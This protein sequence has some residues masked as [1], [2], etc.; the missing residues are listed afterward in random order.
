MAIKSDTLE[1]ESLSSNGKVKPPSRFPTNLHFN[2]SQESGFDLGQFTSTLRRRFFIVTG[3]TAVVTAGTLYWSLSRPPVYQSKFQ[4]LIEPVTAESQVVSEVK[5][6]RTTASEDPVGVAASSSKLDYATQIQVLLSPKLLNP[7][8]QQLRDRYPELEYDRAIKNI[9]INQV[10]DKKN[11]TKVLQVNY[12]SKTLEET[13]DVINLLSKSY[14]K[15]SLNERQTNLS[16]AIQFMSTQV[17][18]V[19]DQVRKIESDLQNFRERYGLIDPTNLNAQVTSQIGNVQQTLLTN[20]I[21]I[22]EQK[23]LYNSIQAQIQSSTNSSKA[24]SVLS[25]SPEY[26]KLLSQLQETE[27]KLSI[28]ETKLTA[29]H[30]DVIALKEARDKLIPLLRQTAQANVGSQLANEVKNPRALPYQDALR[31]QLNQRFVET[32]L[33]VQALEA[34]NRGAL[35]AK[36]KLDNQIK[37]VPGITRQYENLQRQLQISTATLQRLLTTRESLLIDSARQDVPWELIAAP[38][39]PL[40]V[41]S[42]LARDLALGMLLGL[43]LGIG[44]AL[45]VDR[46]NDIIYSERELRQEVGLPILGVIPAQQDFQGLA[47]RQEWSN[48]NLEIFPNETEQSKR[49]PF[50]PF[51]EAFRSLYS[52]ICLLNPDAPITTLVISSTASG[53]GKT[54]VAIHLAQAAAAMGRRVLLVDTDLRRPQIHNLLRINGH[55]GIV[56]VIGIDCDVNDAIQKWPEEDSFFVLPAGTPPVE[57]TRILVSHK[58]R[59]LIEVFRSSYDLVVFDAP[60]MGLSDARLLGSY[61]DGLLLVAKIGTVGRSPLRDALR[62]LYEVEVPILGIVA[63]GVKEDQ[64]SYSLYGDYAQEKQPKTPV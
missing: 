47:F 14:L 22:N 24:A 45:L 9:F 58:F 46:A 33:K 55:P 23:A 25:E 11:L 28:A 36:A 52:Q 51:L 50:S 42:S 57:P 62:S 34:R 60:P 8:L 40:A 4:L 49:Y 29:D 2:N 38:T 63:N 44:V 61:T 15:Y 16:R 30:P 43:T 10:S 21:E 7:V 5:G 41:P 53:E 56:D 3:V 39:L 17:P 19:K 64:T 32:A 26:T 54:T 1:Q 12:Q 6:E 35:E 48:S 27:T 20:E 59:N 37:L 31:R 13:Q 18:K